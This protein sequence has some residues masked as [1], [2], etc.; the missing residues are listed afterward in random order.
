M[1][2]SGPFVDRDTNELDTEQILSEAVP[3]AGLILLFGVVALVPLAIGFLV[4][5][6]STFTLALTV[7][8]QFV[9]AV[10]TAVILMYVVARG[11]Q[12]AKN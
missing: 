11:I 6:S 4:P 9:F 12:L 10:G 5:V 8:A 3:V 2:D 1:S 7:L